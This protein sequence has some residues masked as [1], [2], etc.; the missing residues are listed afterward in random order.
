MTKP[1]KSDKIPQH[2]RQWTKKSHS[3]KKS[4]VFFLSPKTKQKILYIRHLIAQKGNKN[5]VPS[6]IFFVIGNYL[7]IENYPT[8][9]FLTSLFSLSLSVVSF[10]NQ[11]SGKRLSTLNRH[12]KKSRAEQLVNQSSKLVSVFKRLKKKFVFIF[13]FCVCFRK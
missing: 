9:I 5:R 12:T 2:T 7:M 11:I 4:Q 1:Q 10:Q 8:N 3:K 6:G 13:F